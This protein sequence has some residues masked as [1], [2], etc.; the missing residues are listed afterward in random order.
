M[1]VKGKNLFLNIE[2][3]T[4]KKT[5]MNVS[6]CIFHRKIRQSGNHY[7]LSKCGRTE[8]NFSMF[9]FGGVHSQE[10]KNRI[11]TFL[12]QNSFLLEKL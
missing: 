3:K 4:K 1:F 2:K 12:F 8:K 11:L 7:E 10:A 6:K 9:I 5:R